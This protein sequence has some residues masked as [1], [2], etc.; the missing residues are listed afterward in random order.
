MEVTCKLDTAADNQKYY[1]MCINYNGRLSWPAAVFRGFFAFKLSSSPR[2]KIT[3]FR[4]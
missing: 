3:G 2:S 4:D 1:G